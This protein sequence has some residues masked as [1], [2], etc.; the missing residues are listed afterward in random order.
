MVNKVIA[1]QQF[2]Q[3]VFL[4]DGIFIPIHNNLLLFH[5]CFYVTTTQS[6]KYSF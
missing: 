6:L 2:N 4:F 3:K 5:F 1:E